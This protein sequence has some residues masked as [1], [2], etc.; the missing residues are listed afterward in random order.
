MLRDL[1]QAATRGLS[2]RGFHLKLSTQAKLDDF[3]ISIIFN[4]SE[5]LGTDLHL[6]LQFQTFISFSV[7]FI[8]NWSF[9]T[10]TNWHKHSSTSFHMAVFEPFLNFIIGT[11][12][13]TEFCY[14]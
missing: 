11:K 3:H 13:E 4:A 12:F 8:S 1:R 6:D 7:R 5:L 14:Q 2:E 10:S 9:C